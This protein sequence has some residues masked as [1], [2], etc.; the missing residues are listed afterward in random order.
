MFHRSRAVACRT[1]VSGV[2][3]A[4][5]AER[6]RANYGA[7]MAISFELCPLF[8]LS[9]ADVV[10]A[11]VLLRYAEGSCGS[12]SNSY[13]PFSCKGRGGTG[14]TNTG[15]SR[16]SNNRSWTGNIKG[17]SSNASRTFAIAKNSC[18]TSS[19]RLP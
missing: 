12:N 16:Y 5:R 4:P 6:P 3:F 9:V 14:S 15:S 17:W 1:A 2:L 13:R 7:C 10:P 8:L 11:F 18:S 19:S